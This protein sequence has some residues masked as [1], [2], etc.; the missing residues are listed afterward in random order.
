MSLFIR[1]LPIVLRM[2]L[3]LL[4]ARNMIAQSRRRWYP[5]EHMTAALDHWLD[6]LGYDGSIGVV[7]RAAD[8][9]RAD[10]PYAREIGLLLRQGGEVA[11]SAVYEVDRVPAVCFLEPSSQQALDP[12]FVNEVRRKIWNQNLVSIVV[13]VRGEQASFYPAPRTLAPAAPLTLS[14]ARLDGPFSA[15]EVAG[16]SIYHRL[17]TWFDRK[18]RVDRILQE[19]LGEAVRALEPLGLEMEQSQLL[20]GK[21]IF[22]A[23]L[24]HRGIVGARYRERH[25]V[26]GLLE[27]LSTADG[28]GLD[29]LFR[30]LKTDFNGDLLQIE[31]GSNVDWASLDAKVFDL[32]AQFLLQTRIRD[33]QASLWPYDFRY[34][35]VELLSGIYE[36]FLGHAQR[37]SGAF[38]TPRHLATLA[39]D[40]AFSG[41]E[42]PW[43]EVVL[44]GACGS[45]ILLT[46]A[47]RRMLGARQAT[48]KKPLSFEDRQSILLSGIRGGD[49][50]NAA[51]KV[52]AFSLYLALLEDLMPS[53]ISRLQDDQD[54]KLPPLLG[55]VLSK[56]GRGDFFCDNNSVAKPDSA[57]IVISNPPWF[58][59]EEGGRQPYED[60]WLARF[61]SV[62]PRRQI[63]Q[64][65]ARRATD[66]LAPGGRICLILPSIVIGGADSG[67]YLQSWFREMAPE[68]ILNL[69]DM[70]RVLFDG[71]VHPTVV[72][73]GRRR[74]PDQVGRIPVRES[75]EYIVPKADV[76]LAFGRL[77]VHSFDRK[78]LATHA[79]VDDTEVFRTYF[80]GTELDESLIARLRLFGTF[81]EHARGADARFVICKGFHKTDN[82]KAAVS[83]DPLH[84]YPYLSTARGNSKLPKDRLFVVHRD[85]E[86]FPTEIQTVADYGSKQGQAFEGVRVIFPDGADTDTLEVRACYADKPFCFTQTVGAII[87]REGDR[88]FMQFT[89][90]YLRSKL[91]R[92]LLFYTSFS[93]THERPHVKLVEIQSLPFLT[94]QDHPKP[95][96]AAKVVAKVAALLKP[97]KQMSAAAEQAEWPSVRAQLDELV[98]DYFGLSATER[99]VVGETCDYLIPSRQPRLLKVMDQPLQLTPRQGEFTAYTKLLQEELEV[100][101]DRL[102]GAGHFVVE[103]F[104]PATSRAGAV[105]VV[106]ISIGTS[107]KANPGHAKDIESILEQL[108]GDDAFPQVGTQAL[109]VASDFLLFHGGAYYLVKPLVRRLWLASA[110]AHDAS[111][112]V[113]TVRQSVP[114]P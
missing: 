86:T 83:S 62:L 58:E 6:S 89:T 107:S 35:P 80:W 13:V 90:A 45:G 55:P 101:R 4:I 112:I 100:W 79:A 9:V 63:A 32:L 108:R 61:K 59:P 54:V 84:A 88:D 46:S 23:Y 34:I 72:V 1:H 53:D 60:W 64:A 19:N 77:T 50:S 3:I 81:E 99:K 42:E 43:R 67:P 47:Y 68:R 93:L 8:D 24:E 57:T 106:R 33:G 94:P 52:T 103:L 105:A 71:A 114:A 69:A 40:E 21:C 26:G 37:D 14:S 56:E 66:A 102:Q 41:L 30:R 75:F 113:Q 110:A 111:R 49:I 104:R 97:Y 29:K 73:T 85:L 7:H 78:R 17:P 11:S 12:D 5:R 76:S 25:R 91:A 48:Q 16:G 44:D 92:Y 27:L 2:V 74:L 22:V 10:H 65:F 39:V 15:A 31:G 70:R 109:S 18:H 36:T 82:S 28:R 96:Y 98:C 38:Y 20:L 87:D 51:C 95:S